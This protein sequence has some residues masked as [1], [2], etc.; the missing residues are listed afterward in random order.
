MQRR[1]SK[2]DFNTFWLVLQKYSP[3]VWWGIL[4]SWQI[5]HLSGGGILPKYT[6]LHFHPLR[7]RRVCCGTSSMVDKF[8][9]GVWRGLW[10]LFAF[11]VEQCFSRYKT[12]HPVLI[13]P[14]AAANP[15]TVKEIRCF[16]SWIQKTEE[17]KK[18]VDP[19][20]CVRIPH[21]SSPHGKKTSDNIP[22]KVT[23]E[24]NRFVS[25]LLF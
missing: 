23:N 13:M 4:N 1:T 11:C 10:A 20:S 3:C 25:S 15:S 14:K 17:E 2:R 22:K 16:P 24:E 7:Q 21:A 5:C 18:S 19:L 9:A 12:K 6:Q 8:P